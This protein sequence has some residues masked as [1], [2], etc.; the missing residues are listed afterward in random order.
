MMQSCASAAKLR[1]A[2]PFYDSG[3][4]AWAER[5][6]APRTYGTVSPESD[7]PNW[8]SPGCSVVSDPGFSGDFH[9]M[10]RMPSGPLSWTSSQNATRSLRASATI[11]TLQC[12]AGHRAV[13]ARN[14]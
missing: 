12:R 11:M 6:T 2:G 4:K 13:R 1:R 9:R 3:T 10:K 8:G 7:V 14:H 5:D